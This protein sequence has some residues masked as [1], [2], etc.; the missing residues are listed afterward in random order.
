MTNTT[1]N[2]I[3]IECSAPNEA[4]TLLDAGPNL[5]IHLAGPSETG[6]T[7]PILCGFNRFQRDEDGHYAIGFSVG[8]GITGPGIEHDVCTGCVDLADGRQIKGTNAA[9]VAAAITEASV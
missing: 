4:Y 7:G 8:G 3:T 2:L 5:T 1:A 9:K 6:G